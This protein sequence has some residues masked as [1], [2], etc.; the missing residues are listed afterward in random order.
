MTE[1]AGAGMAEVGV[2]GWGS[3]DG[4][5]APRGGIP[6]ASAGMTDLAG[7][8]YSTVMVVESLSLPDGLVTVSE[9]VLAPGELKKGT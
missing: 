3:V 8:G 7:A 9:T 2:R 4:L 1:L 6:A 5:G